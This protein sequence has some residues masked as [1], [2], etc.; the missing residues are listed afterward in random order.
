MSGLSTIH[1]ATIN[2]TV[3]IPV[4][5]SYTYEPSDPGDFRHP[6]VAAYV[7]IHLINVNSDDV[8]TALAEGNNSQEIESVTLT[9]HEA[10]LGV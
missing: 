1:S 2:V 6:P 5:V 4:E 9:D 3:T 7:D 8:L 10:S